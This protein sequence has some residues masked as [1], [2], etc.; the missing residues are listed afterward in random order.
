MCIV[1]TKLCIYK[2]GRLCGDYIGNWMDCFDDKKF[3]FPRLERAWFRFFHMWY[4]PY[5]IHPLLLR[6]S[7][8]YNVIHSGLIL[9]CGLISR[10]LSFSQFYHFGQNRQFAACCWLNE[11]VCFLPDAIPHSGQFPSQLSDWLTTQLRSFTRGSAS[12][13]SSC[14]L[15]YMSRAIQIRFPYQL[16][17]CQAIYPLFVHSF[18]NFSTY[19][20]SIIAPI[21]HS[22]LKRL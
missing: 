6:S 10:Y 14:W 19:L 18:I 5:A 13:V 2:N 11:Q 15:I 20:I 1:L 4:F 9:L 22:S 21:E 7:E 8:T 17:K 16:P 12:R 3:G